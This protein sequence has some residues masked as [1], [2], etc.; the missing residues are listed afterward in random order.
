MLALGKP[1][2]L[3]YRFGL[4]L[5]LGAS[6]VWFVPLGGKIGKIG[7]QLARR[8]KLWPSLQARELV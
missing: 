4:G 3:V 2:E 7:L 6:D 5:G 8:A 1:C